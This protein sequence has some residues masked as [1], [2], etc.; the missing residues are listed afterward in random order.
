MKPEWK[1]KRQQQCAC[2]L[3][4]YHQKVPDV[5]RK[6]SPPFLSS[7]FCV[8]YALAALVCRLASTVA[9]LLAHLLA[10]V[11]TVA[12]QAD[13]LIELYLALEI[14]PWACSASAGAERISSMA[15]IFEF[16]TKR[17]LRQRMDV[18]SESE[19]QDSVRILKLDR[20]EYH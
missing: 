16:S 12:C 10:A 13:E 3:F 4:S 11:G 9:A 6:L 15:G 2:G 8:C 14:M 1:E 7:R 20:K 18:E 5:Q 17:L 19:F